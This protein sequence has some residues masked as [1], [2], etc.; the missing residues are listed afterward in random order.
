MR[1]AFRNSALRGIDSRLSA[2]F[3]LLPFLPQLRP[4]ISTGI[5][6]LCFFT[7]DQTRRSL[8]TFV[9]RTLSLGLARKTTMTKYLQPISAIERKY[10][11]AEDALSSL[12][13]HQR[14]DGFVCVK[15]VH[16]FV[17]GTRIMKNRTFLCRQNR[18]YRE[19]SKKKGK[20]ATPTHKFAPSEHAYC[21]R[22]V[23]ACNT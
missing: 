3:S 4:L 21:C 9:C 14:L 1:D 11:S 23:T 12:L 7:Y 18:S 5:P 10:A 15:G 8:A 20:Y 16:S 17:L 2:P 19:W 13:D 22:R 6:T